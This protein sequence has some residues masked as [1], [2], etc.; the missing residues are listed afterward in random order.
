MLYSAIFSSKHSPALKFAQFLLLRNLLIISVGIKKEADFYP[1]K[2][3]NRRSI[4]LQKAVDYLVKD[5]LS[6]PER[7][8]ATPSKGLFGKTDGHFCQVLGL[9]FSKTQ[10]NSDKNSNLRSDK[11]ALTSPAGALTL[12]HKKY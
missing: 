5:Q 7:P 1:R 11:M 9:Y 12:I 3:S 4:T 6:Q 10:E 8:S 2:R